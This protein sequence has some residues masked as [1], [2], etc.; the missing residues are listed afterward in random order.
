MKSSR[1]TLR[2]PDHEWEH[3]TMDAIL[4]RLREDHDQHVDG[5]KDLERRIEAWGSKLGDCSSSTGALVFD[6]AASRLAPSGF[7]HLSQENN[8]G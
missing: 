7:D 1:A 4:D 2:N 6:Q 3:E 5:I 8:R